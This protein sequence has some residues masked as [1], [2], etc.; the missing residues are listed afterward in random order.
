MDIK[1][2]PDIHVSPSRDIMGQVAGANVEKKITELLKKKK[3]IRMI[4]AAAPSQNEMLAYLSASDKIDWDRI[5]V[6]NMDEYIGLDNHAP[7]L[8]STYLNQQLFEKVKLKNV[9]LINGQAPVEEEI[10]RYAALLTEAPID[11]VCLGIGENGHIAFNDPPVADFNDP[12]I[13]KMVQLDKACR[14]QQVNEGCFAKL[15]DVPKKALT[16]TIPVI[17]AADYLFC[18]VPGTNKREAVYNTLNSTISPSCPASVLRKHPNCK[19]YFDEE[20]YDYVA[21][22]L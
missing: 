18:I 12:Q 7:Q 17:M 5:T 4:F 21:A 2:S 19:F 20:A 15:D 13:I 10:S 22:R 16:I 6:F 9:H 8:F 1:Y 3:T 14:T 11:I